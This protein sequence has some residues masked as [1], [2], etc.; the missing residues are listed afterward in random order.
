[1]CHA[2]VPGTV[3][4]DYFIQRV[5]KRAM[6]LPCTIAKKKLYLLLAHGIHY[7]QA[8]EIFSTFRMQKQGERHA[9]LAHA[10]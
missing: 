2:A 9:F 8:L 6:P 4:G 1:V 7:F 5:A 10:P 3:Q